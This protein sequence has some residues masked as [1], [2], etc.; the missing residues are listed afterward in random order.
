MSKSDAKVDV[1]GD[2]ICVKVVESTKEMDS[3]PEEATIQQHQAPLMGDINIE[4]KL[5]AEMEEPFISMLPPSAVEDDPVDQRMIMSCTDEQQTQVTQV[6]S[7]LVD[8]LVETYGQGHPPLRT[9]HS[10]KMRGDD[11][12]DGSASVELPDSFVT[13]ADSSIISTRMMC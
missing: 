6:A 9:E 3:I 2:K 10:T 4:N 12:R 1:A 5:D 7:K 13:P 11:T 8:V